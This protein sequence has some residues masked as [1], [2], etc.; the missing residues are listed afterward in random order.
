LAERYKLSGGEIE[1]IARKY[2][3]DNIINNN[4]NNLPLLNQFCQKEKIQSKKIIQRVGFNMSL[5]EDL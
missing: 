2:I 5:G 1:N 3:I 4:K